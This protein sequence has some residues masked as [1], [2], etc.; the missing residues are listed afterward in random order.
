MPVTFVVHVSPALTGIASVNVPVEITSPARS[1]GLWAT[2][3]SHL[4]CRTFL[5]WQAEAARGRCSRTRQPSPS[6]A[7]DSECTPPCAHAHARAREKSLKNFASCSSRRPRPAPAMP[8]AGALFGVEVDQRKSSGAWRLVMWHGGYADIVIRLFLFRPD[9]RC[10]Q[11]RKLL[12]H[13]L[14]RV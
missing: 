8:E 9:P 4:R 14:A 3:I 11:S 7:S 1:G 13:F 12:D 2:R 10:V 6:V 5:Q